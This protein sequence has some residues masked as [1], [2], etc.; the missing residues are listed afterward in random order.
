MSDESIAGNSGLTRLGDRIL[1][2]LAVCE[3]NVGGK[4]LQKL[5]R[6]CGWDTTADGGLLTQSKLK[7]ELQ[8]L[9]DQRL[10]IATTRTFSFVAI[11]PRIMDSVIQQSAMN[12]TLDLISSAVESFSEQLEREMRVHVDDAS[13]L[14]ARRRARIAFY[15]GDV[16]AFN[17]ATTDLSKTS[18]EMQDLGLLDPFN[19]ELYDRTPVELQAAFIVD[20]A[21][22]AIITGDEAAPAIEAFRDYAES[23]SPLSGVVADWWIR[24]LVVSGDLDELR[25]VAGSETTGAPVAAGCLA[26][27]TGDFDSAEASFDQLTRQLP[28]PA[29]RKSVVLPDLIG[30]LHVL[31][32]LRKCDPASRSTLKA[33]GTAAMKDWP[34]EWTDIPTLIHVATNYADLPSATTKAKFWTV[35]D[36]PRENRVP[37]VQLIARYLNHWFMPSEISRASRDLSQRVNFYDQIGMHWLAALCEDGASLVAR[38]S[39]KKNTPPD[40]RHSKLGTFPM[41]TW[42]EPP[43]LWKRKLD[44]VRQVLNES[45]GQ[46]KNTVSGSPYE[47]RLIWEL[48]LLTSDTVNNPSP[49]P[50]IQKLSKGA[51]TGGRPV[52]LERLY[53]NHSDPEFA[54]LTERDRAVCR[55]ITSTEVSSGYRSYTETIYEFDPDEALKALIGHPLVFTL[56]NRTQPLEIISRK[57]QLVIKRKHSGLRIELVPP[58]RANKKSVIIRDGSQ[59]LVVVNF[60]AEQLKIAGILD[61]ALNVPKNGES[62]V[63]ATAKALSSMFSVQSDITYDADD[64]GSNV[65]SVAANP[66]PHLHLLP[67]HAGLRAEFFVQPFGDTGP[68]FP[69]GQGGENIFTEIQGEA[70]STKRNLKRELKLAQEI[71]EACPVLAMNS[72][73]KCSAAEFPA[74]DDALEFLLQIEPV[75]ASG[76]LIVHWPQG[77]TLRIAGSVTEKQLHVRIERDRDWFAASG[78]VVVDELVQMDLMKLVDLVSVSSSRFVLMT[79]GRFLALTEQLRKRI[80]A[81]GAYGE[82]NGDTLRFPPIRASAFSDLDEWCSL[83][84]DKHWK[85]CLKRIQDAGDVVADVPSTLNAELRDYQVEGFRWL[86]RLAH[87]GAGACLADDMGLGK[88]LQAIAMLLRRGADGPALVIAPM[89]V[90][91]NWEAELHRFAP[92]LNPRIFGTGDRDAFIA[93]LGPRDVVIVSYGLLHTEAERLQG[94]QWNTAILDEA[95]AIKNTLTKRSQAAM[96]LSADFRLILT[97]TPIEN[98]LGELWN[99]FQFI[100]PG[101]LGSMEQFHQRFAVPIERDHNR[102][103]SQQLKRLVQPF[104]LRRTKTQVLSELPPRTEVTVSVTLP[105]EEAVLYEAARQRAVNELTMKSDDVRGQHVRILAEIMRL[106]RVCCH[107][108]LLLPEC[109]LPGAKLAAFSETIDELI[110]NKHKALVFSQFVDHLAIL[111]AELDRKKVAYQYLDGSTSMNDRKKA[112]EAFQNGEGDV[113]L[114]SLKAG[115]AGLN[116]TAAD[117]VLQMDPW[118]NPAVEDQ[119]AD[120]AHRMGQLRP[121]TIYRFITRGTIEEKI[122]AL[123]AT[124]RDLADSLLEGTDTTGRLSAEELLALIR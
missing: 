102:E 57:P 16:A 37:I 51:W 82:R 62:D 77:Q 122:L 40:Q 109:N 25:K 61:G 106:R 68:Y 30:L 45:S 96:S 4:T 22:R 29:G 120:R 18:L 73:R 101:L 79:D 85:A 24:L 65:R 99:L 111:R 42:I 76:N 123:H 7:E 23:H 12:G 91:F 74:A 98:H 89:S 67:F 110:E 31:L 48:N 46:T 72:D 119:A 36:N 58:P 20:E 108:S 105:D 34:D 59:R 84:A 17:A 118:W 8:T 107:P 55:C 124:K 33:L 26:F 56:G 69:S 63:L 104:L 44:F 70:V 71:V 75:R 47:E 28:K 39:E 113:F 49:R 13:V 95:Q 94:V 50:I 86:C 78:E 100:N 121:V 115:G 103:V 38:G 53:K 10:V 92:T 6:A 27:L 80:I 32:V 90:C 52:S 60:T 93:D 15:R 64:S 54:F 41:L 1:Q 117:Y 9:R 112:V 3:S 35:L 14:T 88:T 97:G 114:I 87:W 2:V 5:L 19:R 66:L 11:H 116:L 21:R 43:S 81:F 83:K